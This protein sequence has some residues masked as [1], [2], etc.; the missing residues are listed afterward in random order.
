MDDNYDLITYKLSTNP[1]FV[2]PPPCHRG[3]KGSHEV[4]LR[5]LHRYEEKNTWT[6]GKL[7][8][9]TA[10]DPEASD[11]IIINAT[12]KGPSSSPGRG[13]PKEGRMLSPVG[14]EAPALCARNGQRVTTDWELA[15]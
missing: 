6:I 11:V 9:H 12:G 2:S 4:H 1:A 15:P 10:E 3:P 13:A 8:E 14:L 7:K 5:E